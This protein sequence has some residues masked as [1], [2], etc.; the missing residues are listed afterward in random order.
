MQATMMKDGELLADKGVVL[1]I[2]R[3]QREVLEG[4]RGKQVFA[5]VDPT[6][7]NLLRTI[8]VSTAHSGWRGA[9][10]HGSIYIFFLIP[11]ENRGAGVLCNDR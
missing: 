1:R 7:P 5:E 8:K 2:L 9:S 10:F 6:Q 11:N 3:K 4:E